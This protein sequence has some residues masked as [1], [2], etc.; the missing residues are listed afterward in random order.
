MTDRSAVTDERST[1][2]TIEDV[3]ITAGVS[4]ATVS[5]ALRDL[6]KVAPSTRQRVLD[7]AA[8]MNYV[9]DPAASR[10]AAGKTRTVAVA[11]PVLDVWYGAKIVAGIEAVLKEANFDLLL[12][13]ITDE[14]ERQR[15]V[16]GRG[17]WWRRSDAVILVDISLFEKE[18]ERL[19]V[20][21]AQIVTIGTELPQFSSVRLEEKDSAQEAT[22]HLIA[23]GHRRI[24]L[25]K[26]DRLVGQFRVPLFR[27][28]GFFEALSDAGIDCSPELQLSGGFSID[29]GREA[30]RTLL[31]LAEPPTAV[32][33]M[34]DE[35]AF[36]ALYEL[37]CQGLTSP[38]DVAI[39]GFDDHDISEILGLS[40]IRQDV[41]AIGAAAARMALQCVRHSRESSPF[42]P[43]R[44]VSPTKLIVRETS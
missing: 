17:A 30:M 21:G 44:V 12:Y 6:P 27:E 24:A 25:L 4:V 22:E 15:F 41:E 5:R 28:E 26:G 42:E 18:A 29:G 35:M 14:Q 11:V 16:A 7:V 23:A 39:V 32:F 1:K 33:A 40:T 31:E 38:Q 9:V 8:A 3:A 37:K 2:F 19:A 20:S 36:G 34:S 10:L 43:E 13:A